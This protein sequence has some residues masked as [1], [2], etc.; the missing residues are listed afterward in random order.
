MQRSEPA[1][2]SSSELCP[3][4]NWLQLEVRVVWDTQNCHQLGLV[5][6]CTSEASEHH[7]SHWEEEEQALK[8]TS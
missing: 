7:Q 6:C 1:T 5:V 3:R 2:G 8:N 4:G